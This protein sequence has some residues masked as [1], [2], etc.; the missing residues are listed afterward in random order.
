M[1]IRWM[2]TAII[3]RHEKPV[4]YRVVVLKELI[5]LGVFSD[6]V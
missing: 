2:K 4:A 6:R 1:V 5:A 3:N